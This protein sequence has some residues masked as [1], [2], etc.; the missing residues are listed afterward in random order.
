MLAK[1]RFGRNDVVT[2]SYPDEL[3]VTIVADRVDFSEAVAYS[4]QGVRLLTCMQNRI[5]LCK[6]THRKLFYESYEIALHI[7]HHI[8]MM[9]GMT[10]QECTPLL[11]A[12]SGGVDS[13]VL[14]DVLATA[15]SRPLIVAHV[16]HGIRPDSHEDEAFVANLAASYSLPFTSVRLNLGP[17][18][19]EESARQ[20]R[21]AWLEAERIRHGAA[22]IATAHHEDD[23]IETMIINLSR[24]TGWRGL[25]SLRSTATRYRPLLSW[26]K[27]AVVAYA[28]D[29]QLEWRED[30]TNESLAYFRNRIRHLIMPTLS[31]GAR[32]AFI[33]LYTSQVE[34][35]TGIENEL[36]RL[37]GCYAENGHLR[38]Y[39]LV[40]I[41]PN[42]AHELLRRWLPYPLE[43]PRYDDLLLFAKTAR[44][45]AKW[46]LDK[47]RFVSATKSALIVL[48]PRD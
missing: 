37:L 18:T 27:A 11:V 4:V 7:T 45:G 15:K 32:A 12:V 31:P 26:S 48:P 39:P 38:R 43:R 47:E 9:Q 19:S 34:L 1:K 2:A 23:V 10:E 30:S 3:L 35:R 40:T 24:G 21:Y 25:S 33:E 41:E 16:D 42:L 5:S 20:A 46:S 44:P 14:L 28:L 36:Q 6:R 8:S 13:V 17:G 29:R 22:A